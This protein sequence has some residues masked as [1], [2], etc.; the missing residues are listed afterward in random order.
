MFAGNGRIALR[1]VT[2]VGRRNRWSRR[3]Q[4]IA[5]QALNDARVQGLPLMIG[6]GRGVQ[7]EQTPRRRG[8]FGVDPQ[9][10]SS[11]A[12]GTRDDAGGA[13]WTVRLPAIPNRDQQVDLANEK[14]R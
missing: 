3:H 5:Q 2:R 4:D 9:H 12:A 11:F 14:C 7:G 1:P 6:V 8:M 10:R 13:A